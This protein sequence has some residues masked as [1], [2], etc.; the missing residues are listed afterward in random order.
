M[1]AGV[2][3]ESAKDVMMMAGMDAAIGLTEACS[4]GTVFVRI[5]ELVFRV[6]L[7]P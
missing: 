7:E 5:K 6:P 4:K 3:L 1:V 2:S